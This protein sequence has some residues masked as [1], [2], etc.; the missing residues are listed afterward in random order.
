MA[1]D[2]LGEHPGLCRQSVAQVVGPRSLFGAIE[3]R[4]IGAHGVSAH[5]PTKFYV[6]ELREAYR[7]GGGVRPPKRV[8]RSGSGVVVIDE[9][10]LTDRPAA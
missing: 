2:E 6:T 3:D 10:P 4:E 7:S 8:K 9:D 5:P 1:A